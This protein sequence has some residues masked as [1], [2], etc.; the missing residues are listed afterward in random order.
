MAK[1]HHV[2]AVPGLGGENFGFR[3][4]VNSWQRYGFTPHIHN[5]NWKDGEAFKPKLQRLVRLID[6]LSS[7]NDFVSLVGTSAGGSAVLNAFYER[8]NKI[9]RVINV[10]GRLKKGE[11]VFPSLNLAA[12][13]SIAFKESVLLCE[14]NEPSLT[15][16][17]RAKILTIR[18]IFDEIV[19]SVTTSI[20]GANNS[21]IFSIEHTLSIILAMTIYSNLVIEFLQTAKKTQGVR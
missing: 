15:Q 1:R 7:N 21:R 9:Q 18:P 5:V 4:I 6:D 10:C 12:R 20:K 13:K 2:I 8:R 11:N 17:E 19:P 3:A 16:N 14:K